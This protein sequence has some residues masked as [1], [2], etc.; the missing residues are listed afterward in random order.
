MR[1][2]ENKKLVFG[3]CVLLAFT[4]FLVWRLVRPTNI[5]VVDE[6]FERPMMAEIPEGLSS[7]SAEECGLCH[8]A[9]NEEWSG[10]MH[11]RAW[12]D[13]Y[14]QV[15]YRFDGSQQICLNCHTPLENQQEYRVVGFRDK[16]KFDPILEPNPIFDAE[17]QQEGVTCAV[18]HVKDGKIVGPEVSR[19][20]THSAERL[21]V[22]V[23]YHLLD[24]ARRRRIGYQNQ[25]PI[26]YPIYRESFRLL[27][28]Q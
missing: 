3:L 7:L 26:H 9:I 11:A 18:C 6:R 1:L 24:E 15:D 14:F 22:T 12:T 4:V 13:P 10:S 2:I 25:D 5:F 23:T 27:E 19:N 16:E 21:D 17:L 28:Q 20:L 8:E